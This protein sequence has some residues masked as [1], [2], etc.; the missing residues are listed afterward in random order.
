MKEKE[1][2]CL[3]LTKCGKCCIK[4]LLPYLTIT[5]HILA[6]KLSHSG[7]VNFN[8]LCNSSK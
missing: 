3:T 8:L 6:A 1:L 7:K 2:T 5:E 4:C